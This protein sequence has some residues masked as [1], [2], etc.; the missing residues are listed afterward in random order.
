MFLTNQIS[1]FFKEKYLRKEVSY[2]INFC[3]QIDMQVNTIMFVVARH[4]Q[5]TKDKNLPISLQYL[6]KEVRA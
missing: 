6:M 2:Q 4:V 1:G 5:S 3:L